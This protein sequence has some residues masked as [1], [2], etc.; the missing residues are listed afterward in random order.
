MLRETRTVKHRVPPYQL[1][2]VSLS[3]GWESQSCFF[4]PLLLHFDYDV[5]TDIL[6]DENTN[7]NP[8]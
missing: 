7:I 6:K 8:F 4:A 2:C 3:P 5:G 1:C